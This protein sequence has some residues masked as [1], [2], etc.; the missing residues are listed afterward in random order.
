MSDTPSGGPVPAVKGTAA[1]QARHI[2]GETKTQLRNVAGDVRD[3]VNE[4]ARTQNDKLVSSIRQTADQLDEMRGERQDSPAATVVSR[5]ADS[6]R[7]LADYLDRNGP[8]GVLREVQDFARR[9]P[10]TFL[11][12]ALVAG[13]VVGR[14][15]KGAAKADPAAGSERPDTDSF[16][17]S[18][19]HAADRAETPGSRYDAGSTGY[20]GPP[21][22][23]GYAAGTP[24]ATEYAASGAGTPLVVE[25]EYVLDDPASR[26]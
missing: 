5:V 6:G 14:L 20:A 4:Q 22:E 15:G 18:P 26:P 12:S 10:G 2:A 23:A 3:R 19:T 7:Q 25:E 21:D 16:V 13:L 17:S 24:V 11:A 8:D 1:E 9:R